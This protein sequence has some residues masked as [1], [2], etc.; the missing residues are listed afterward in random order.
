MNVLNGFA[1]FSQEVLKSG[2]GAFFSTKHWGGSDQWYFGVGES[3]EVDFDSN[4]FPQFSVFDFEG[5]KHKT[6]FYPQNESHLSFVGA[7]IPFGDMGKWLKLPDLLNFFEE[8]SP[9][10]IKKIQQVQ[11]QQKAG[12]FWVLNLA[13]LVQGELENMSRI[14]KIKLLLGSFYKF[15]ESGQSHC[16]GIFIHGEQLFCSFSPELFLLQAKN[17]VSTFPIKG[18]GGESVLATSQKEISELEM[19]V[20]LMRNDLGQIAQK[21]WVEQSRKLT[22]EDSFF[23]AQ[24]QV[25]AV[26]SNSKFCL[27]DFQKLFPAG[28]ISGAPKQ[29]VLEA[30]KVLEGFDRGFYTGSFGVRV[31]TDC[32]IFN[33]LIRTLFLEKN[34]WSFPV[35]AGIT[36]D[37]DQEQECFELQKKLYCLKKFCSLGTGALE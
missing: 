1:L 35:G 30:I 17:K 22:D 16:G 2:E 10:V 25:S 37:S 18:T 11:I 23:H 14:N 15:L 19:V 12:D 3:K 26:L 28:S 34:T 29:K 21:V 6:L 27:A 13:Q 32:S 8:V 31:D 20:D 36:V 24:A 33:L 5:K 7:D 9:T 4:F